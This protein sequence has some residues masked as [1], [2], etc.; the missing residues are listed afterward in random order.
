MLRIITKIALVTAGA[1]ATTVLATA[2]AL[3][4]A[5]D[6]L[7]PSGTSFT[8][9]NSGSITFKGTINGFSLTVT[10]TGAKLTAK[11]PPASSPSLTASVTS[12]PP[13]TFSG[14]TDNFFGTDTVTTSGTWSLTNTDA[15]DPATEPQSSGDQLTLNIPNGGAKFTSS[16]FPSCT[17][18]ANAST[19]TSSTFNDSTTAT[20]SSANVN[21]TGSG[22]TA[23]SPAKL[24]GTFKSSIS[25]SDTA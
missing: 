1:A 17:V 18:T 19:P 6:T 10:C 16:A 2:P 25:V 8:V 7:T 9:T 14:C 15:G 20:F 22:C 3:A 5:G 4:D 12:S 11:T 23:S 21:V 13:V 24:S